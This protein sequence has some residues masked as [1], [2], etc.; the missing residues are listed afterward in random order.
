V[1]ADPGCHHG[2]LLNDLWTRQKLSQANRSATAAQWFSHFLL[3]AF[4][5]EPADAIRRLKFCRSTIEA[6][7]RSGSG[8]QRAC[9]VKN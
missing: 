3:K 9:F 7:M 2:R 8:F 4:A 1:N 6:Q 5:D